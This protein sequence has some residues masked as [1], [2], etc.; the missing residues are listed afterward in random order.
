MY[1]SDLELRKMIDHIRE[2]KEQS[3][4]NEIKNRDNN[5]YPVEPSVKY[6]KPI[7]AK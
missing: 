4:G 2:I 1:T 7:L 5:H 3:Y 6:M